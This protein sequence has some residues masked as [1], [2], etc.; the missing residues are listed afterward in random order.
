HTLFLREHNRLADQ[1]AAANPTWTDEQIYQ[2]ARRMVGAELEVIVYNEWIPALLGPGAL[3]AY[4]G[5]NPNVNPGIANEFSTA[6]F[7]FAPSQLDNEVDR[8]NNDGTDIANGSIPLDES[9][10]DP[11]LIHFPAGTV[12]PVTGLQSTG[13]SPILKGSASGIA[14]NVDLLAVRSVRD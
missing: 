14:Q 13:I 8:K 4:T 12:D 9:F 7:R 5:Y 2:A 11:N 10:F 6:L 3:P 1:F